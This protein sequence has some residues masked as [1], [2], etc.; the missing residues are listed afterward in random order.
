MLSNPCVGNNFHRAR[1]VVYHTGACTYAH[2]S[3]VKR[4]RLPSML[5]PWTFPKPMK[6]EM[7]PY[8]IDS[9]V[10]PKVTNCRILPK[11]RKHYILLKLI[12]RWITP[13]TRLANVAR[14]SCVCV[15]VCV[16]PTNEKWKHRLKCFMNNLCYI[17]DSSV[18]PA[19]TQ[20]KLNMIFS[21]TQP[22][23]S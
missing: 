6:H 4:C 19:L 20:D 3:S 1:N 16:R 11:P 10:F 8:T 22:A 9:R 23:D 5:W 21:W 14:A 7:I 2:H 12:K 18:K 15:C 17:H 13:T